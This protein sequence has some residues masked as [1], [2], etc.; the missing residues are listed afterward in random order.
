MKSSFLDSLSNLFLEKTMVENSSMK[1]I[2]IC[3][4]AMAERCLH[5]VATGI[6]CHEL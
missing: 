5:Y 2:Y 3:K 4:M 6:V 1:N